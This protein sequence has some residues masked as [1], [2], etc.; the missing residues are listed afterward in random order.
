MIPFIPDPT[1]VI[2]IVGVLVVLLVVVIVLLSG[3]KVA[4]PDEAIIVTSRQKPLKT[5][6]V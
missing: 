3:I 4:K 1:L 2:V 5:G 6:Q